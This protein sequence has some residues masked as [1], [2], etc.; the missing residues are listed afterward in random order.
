M[1]ANI[2]PPAPDAGELPEPG[3]DLE[4]RLTLLEQ[5][6]AQPAEGPSPVG[7]RDVLLLIGYIREL[8]RDREALLEEIEVLELAADRSRTR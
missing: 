3:P 1:R 6:V 4:R 2:E 7:G 8:L 5:R